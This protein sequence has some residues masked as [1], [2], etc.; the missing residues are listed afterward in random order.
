MLN[1][2]KSEIESIKKVRH[3]WSPSS[4]SSSALKAN[5]L[6]KFSY[7]RTRSKSE[8]VTATSSPRVQERSRR[9]VSDSP[10][11]SVTQEN[12]IPFDATRTLSRKSHS[13]NLEATL[14]KMD[15]EH[16]ESNASNESL[17]APSSPSNKKVADRSLNDSFSLDVKD[18]TKNLDE[19]AFTLRSL[20]FDRSTTPPLPSPIPTSS[21][22]LINGNELQLNEKL[23]VGSSAKVFRGKYRDQEVAIKVL[24]NRPDDKQ[25]EDFRKEFEIMR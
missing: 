25:A 9:G 19:A 6:M 15:E 3:E 11:N 18:S 4:P 16:L 8:T 2:V 14:I 24:K 1:E 23:G 13:F 10:R 21:V 12:Y 17:S 7:H 20:D 22:W 5:P